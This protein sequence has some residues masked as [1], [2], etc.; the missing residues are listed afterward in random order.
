M[1]QQTSA[2]EPRFS[3]LRYPILR[4]PNV[5]QTSSDSV[6]AITSSLNQKG[7]T[8]HTRATFSHWHN[9]WASVSSSKPQ[10]PSEFHPVRTSPPPLFNQSKTFFICS[11]TSVPKFLFIYSCQYKLIG[12][13][14]L[15][16]DWGYWFVLKL[17]LSNASSQVK[18]YGQWR[19]LFPNEDVASELLLSILFIALIVKAWKWAHSR[20]KV[21]GSLVFQFM[22]EL[23]CVVVWHK[24]L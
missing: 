5:L 16:L 6:V 23:V 9:I 4:V 10:C 17:A 11:A 7:D 12:F 8:N 22:I 15:V 13:F 2:N 21:L 18:V 1:F 14:I 19:H 3:H 20:P 24:S